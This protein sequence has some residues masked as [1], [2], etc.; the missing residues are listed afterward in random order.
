VRFLE[1]GMFTVMPSLRGYMKPCPCSPV[2]CNEHMILSFVLL[3]TCSSRAST[4]G[5]VGDVCVPVFKMLYPSSDTAS[6]H[7]DV[8]MRTLR[9]ARACPMRRFR[10]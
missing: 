1:I 8:L 10:P 3:G 9:V 2:I 5:L 4:A 7:A 6:A